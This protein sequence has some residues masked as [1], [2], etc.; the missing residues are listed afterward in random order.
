MQGAYIR[1][2]TQML[3]DN[4]WVYEDVQ[5]LDLLDTQVSRI[6]IRRQLA[7]DELNKRVSAVGDSVANDVDPMSIVDQPKTRRPWGGQAF[8]PKTHPSDRYH[9]DGELLTYIKAGRWMDQDGNVFGDDANGK[10]RMLLTKAE[11][12]AEIAKHG[13]KPQIADTPDAPGAEGPYTRLYK[14]HYLRKGLTRQWISPNGTKYFETVF[15]DLLPWTA[16][17]DAPTFPKE[18]PPLPL[19]AQAQFN[20]MPPQ[21]PGPAPSDDENGRAPTQAERA[22]KTA[23][24]QVAQAELMHSEMRKCRL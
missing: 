10:F 3:G 21:A 17:H 24:Q 15:G 9:A 7:L 16:E 2:H 14:G 4:E 22:A 6:M 11:Y 18:A 23:A 1:A 12:C 19:P 20:T 8:K 5:A 13:V